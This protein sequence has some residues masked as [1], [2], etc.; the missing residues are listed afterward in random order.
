M[1][2]GLEGRVE[3]WSGAWR[4]RGVPLVESTLSSVRRLGCDFTGYRL[5]V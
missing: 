1:F 2:R 5:T 3:V 4:M